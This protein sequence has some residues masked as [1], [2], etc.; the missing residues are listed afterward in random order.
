[1]D[2]KCR[3]YSRDMATPGTE[4][5]IGLPTILVRPDRHDEVGV[6]AAAKSTWRLLESA[7]HKA[8]NNYRVGDP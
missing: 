1:M 2:G 3:F 4:I 5:E 6:R 7:M 8:A